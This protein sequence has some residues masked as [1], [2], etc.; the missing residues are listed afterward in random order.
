MVLLATFL[1]VIFRDLTEGILVG[2]MLGTLLFLHR[3]A[4]AVEVRTGW[5]VA[6]EDA[7]DSD[8][9][10]GRTAYDAALAADRDILVHRISGA[11]FFGSAATV[12]VALDRLSEHPR[13][14]VLELSGVPML[15]STAAATIEGFVRKARRHHA[16]V[17]IAGA[18]VAVR[19]TLLAH[20]VRPPHVAYWGSVE[21]AVA[22]VRGDAPAEAQRAA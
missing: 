6:L 11:F 16:E 8:R 9:P 5:P 17:H 4:Q 21:E 3:M 2:F 12:G 14:Y 1:L 15:D 10:E 7:A 22:A 13:A 19:R 18:P 20:G